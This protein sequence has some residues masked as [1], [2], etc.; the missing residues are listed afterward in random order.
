VSGGLRKLQRSIAK[1]EQRITV[2]LRRI[3]DK[4][5]TDLI[6]KPAEI[7]VGDLMIVAQLALLHVERAL[8][9]H[10]KRLGAQGIKKIR[11]EIESRMLEQDQPREKSE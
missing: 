5:H 2:T 6:A 8:E 7:R 4:V 10:G 1:H 11:E 3:D 9:K